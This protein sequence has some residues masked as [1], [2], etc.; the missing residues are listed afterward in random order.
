MKLAGDVVVGFTYSQE[1]RY[2]VLSKSPPSTI[3]YNTSLV[4]PISVIGACT[5]QKDACD[6]LPPIDPFRCPLIEKNPPFRDAC[7]SLSPLNGTSRI[8]LF[9]DNGNR[10]CLGILLEF[11]NGAQRSLGQ[12]RVGIDRSEDYQKPVCICFRHQSYTHPGVSGLLQATTV[13]CTERQEH[14]HGSRDWAC[15]R[16]QGELE[17]WFSIY[18]TRLTVIAD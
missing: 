9:N 10:F 12:C 16:L 18:E 15:F 1:A 3:I 5:T 11:N 6:D 13:T 8:W 17:F 7:F 2:L 4:R 14:S